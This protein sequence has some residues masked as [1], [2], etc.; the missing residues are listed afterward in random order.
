MTQ[1]DLAGRIA[2]LTESFGEAGIVALLLLGV[3]LVIYLML[4]GTGPALLLLLVTYSLIFVEFGGISTAAFFS[5]IL[6]LLL[7]VG[8]KVYFGPRRATTA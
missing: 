6:A 8:S 1:F 7:L 4:R 3:L 2:A 5:R